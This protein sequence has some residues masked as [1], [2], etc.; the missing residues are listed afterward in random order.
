MAATGNQDFGYFVGGLPNP[1]SWVER[2]DYSNDTSNASPKGPLSAGRYSMTATG[3]ASFG[4]F[5]GGRNASYT[6]ISLV[7]RIDYSND[8]ATPVEKGPLNDNKY[9]MGATGSTSFG[10]FAAGRT[11]GPKSSVDRIDYSNDTATATAKASLAQGYGYRYGLAATSARR[12]P[13]VQ[14]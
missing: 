10:Y 12:T 4:Y 8:T 7:D 1:K 14:Y 13:L 3:N 9:D 5:G 11:P 6:T 2:L